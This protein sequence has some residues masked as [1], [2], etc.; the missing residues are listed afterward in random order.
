MRLDKNLYDEIRKITKTDYQYA[1]SSDKKEVLAY[2]DVDVLIEELV[3][4]YNNL[5]E[6]FD[7][8]KE[9]VK[10]NYKPISP[11]EMYGINEK[12]FH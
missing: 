5:K 6:E 9:Y 4:A 7:E 11:Y 1:E 12:D 2:H 10:D 8:F 3:Y